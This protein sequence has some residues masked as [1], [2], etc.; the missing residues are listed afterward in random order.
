MAAKR[1]QTPV[2]AADSI[3]SLAKLVGRGE[4]SVRKWVRNPQWTFGSG[5][6]TAADVDRIKLWATDTLADDPSDRAGGGG[7]GDLATQLKDLPVA[8]QVD[9]G[10]KVSRKKTID[11]KLDRDK[12]LFH[13]VEECKR[14]RLRQIHEVKT[15]MLNMPDGLPVDAET[16]TMIK[17]RILE[18]LRKWSSSEPSATTAQPDAHDAAAPSSTL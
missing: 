18:I 6:W 4:S 16:K 10:L 13:S 7:G 12:G 3:R 5:P 9:V 15:A 11:F 17:G 2:I 8:K 1:P 14:R